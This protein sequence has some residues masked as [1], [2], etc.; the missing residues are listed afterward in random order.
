MQKELRGLAKD[1]RINSTNTENK[2]WLFLKNRQLEGVK[3]RRQ[4]PIGN[5]VADFVSYEK[6]LI[7]E[8][9]GGKHDISKAKDNE[10]D[11]W[12][13]K[14]GYEVL[15]FWNNEVLKNK[16]G[17]LE[18]IRKRLLTPHLTSPARG[19]ENSSKRKEK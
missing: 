12:F 10:R 15:R 7:I 8:L 6:K 18:I 4:E 3:F 17:V 13:K 2:L 11:S 16:D 1:L 5:Y 14:N 9:D 19:E